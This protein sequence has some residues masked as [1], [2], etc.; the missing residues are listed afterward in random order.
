MMMKPTSATALTPNSIGLVIIENMARQSYHPHI[1]D[2]HLPA[3]PIAL[4]VEGNLLAFAQL[5]ANR[6]QAGSL[7][8]L[9]PHIVS[10]LHSRTLPTGQVVLQN[11]SICDD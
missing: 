9:I 6:Q 10:H 5:S 4:L 2:T 1:D 3:S 11:R 7:G 8:A